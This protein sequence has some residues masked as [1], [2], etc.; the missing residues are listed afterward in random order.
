MTLGTLG[1]ILMEKMLNKKENYYLIAFIILCLI[2]FLLKTYAPQLELIR[3][4]FLGLAIILILLRLIE[5][6]K[7]IMKVYKKRPKR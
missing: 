4:I 5:K 1:M 7:L 2:G 6:L 3:Y